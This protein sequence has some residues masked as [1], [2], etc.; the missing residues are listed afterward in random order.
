MI[1]HAWSRFQT[2]LKCAGLLWFSL[3]CPLLGISQVLFFSRAP[4]GWKPLSVGQRFLNVFFTSIFENFHNIF[5]FP[6][7]NDILFLLHCTCVHLTIPISPV[8]GV[9]FSVLFI[10]GVIQFFLILFFSQLFS[11]SSVSSTSL[12]LFILSTFKKK[13]LLFLSLSSLTSFKL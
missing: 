6:H 3:V 1:L 5:N 10:P 8:S 9:V 12:F 11:L 13:F 2:G 4:I 7:L